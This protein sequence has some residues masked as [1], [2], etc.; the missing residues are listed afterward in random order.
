MKRERADAHFNHPWGLA[1]DK[2]GSILEADAR[3]NA[4]RRA[5]MEWAVSTVAGNR[6]AAYA[7]GENAAERFN[8]PTSVVV[9]KGGTI[10][11]AD[12]D[13][14]RMR[15][16]VGWQVTTLAGGC[17]RGVH[18]RRCGGQGELRTASCDGTGRARV[19]ARSRAGRA[20]TLRV[21]DTLLAPQGWM[22]PVDSAA[23]AA[24]E[25]HEEKA[26]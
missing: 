13:N 12:R 5:T 24:A 21:V 3:N 6:E 23:D 9:D 8:C 26:Q 20:D 1:R 2:D 19:S 10:V 22:G 15:K 7:D 18:G 25:A 11:V 16:I 14:D 17:A 4:V